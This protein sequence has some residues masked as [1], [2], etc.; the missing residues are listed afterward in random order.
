MRTLSNSF[1]M[2]LA[3]AAA[4][5]AAV[6]CK[7]SSGTTDGAVP[8]GNIVLT[9][10]STGFVQDQTSGIIGAWYS[11]GD[12]AGPNANVNSTDPEHSDCVAGAL[13]AIPPGT[14]GFTISQCTQIL[15]PVPGQPFVPD[16]TLGMCTS[17]TGAQ[18]LDSPGTTTPDYSDLFGGGIGLDFN[19][20]GGEAGVKGD[21]DL[22]KYVGVSFTFS[23]FTDAPTGDP[24]TIPAGN[25]MRVNFP[26]TGEHGTDSPYWAA[27]KTDDHSPL[28]TTGT[29][30]VLWSEV[31]GPAYLA[32]RSPAVPAPP[33]FPGPGADGL[34][35]VNKVQSIQFQ[36]FTNTSTATPYGFC[37][38]NLTLLATAP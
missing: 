23:A 28:S 16:P 6:G 34:T 17:G 32:T 20:P 11:Y 12:S 25:K 31:L 36:V 18:V 33:F 26:F 30:V 38:N 24:S 29:N 14:G 19:N 27:N 10:T 9:P 3:G 21:I 4:L 2:T 37:V 35:G 1:K 15:T 5:L 22:S 7:S 13:T 8:G